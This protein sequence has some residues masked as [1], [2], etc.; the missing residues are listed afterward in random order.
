MNFLTPINGISALSEKLL[1]KIKEFFWKPLQ[2]RQG[3][4][5]VAVLAVGLAGLA[6][7]AF[8]LVGPPRLL[9]K[10]ES[11][12]FCAGCHVME[13]QHTAWSHA[14]AHRRFRCVD[15]HLPNGDAISHYLWKSIDGMKDAIFF[16]TGQVPERITLSDHG[17]EVLQ[18]NC[19]RCHQETV[20]NMNTSRQCWNCHRRLQHRLT[21]TL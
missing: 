16:H 10:S 8:V 7:V 1:V 17:T 11:P 6:I 3:A 9:A 20:A 2:S 15:C 18:K 19:I 12:A 14:G 13:E 21:G 4:A 5:T